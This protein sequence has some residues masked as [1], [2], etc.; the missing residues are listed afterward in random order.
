MDSHGGVE[1]FGAWAE[2]G[3]TFDL[4]HL[5]LDWE[6]KPFF[7]LQQEDHGDVSHHGELIHQIRPT[8]VTMQETI[9]LPDLQYHL[10]SGND[11]RASQL[12]AYL[13][14]HLSEG[15]RSGDFSTIAVDYYK[16]PNYGR[17]L[18]RGPAAQ[19][20]TREAH[21]K[22]LG[23]A[24]EVDASCC[25]P[26]LLLRKLQVL[27]LEDAAGCTMLK[28]F[29]THYQAWR[30]DLAKY[31]GITIDEAKKE[32][33]RTFYGGKAKVDIPWLRK[34]GHEVMIAADLILQHHGHEYMHELYKDR[35]NPDFSRLC[36]LLSF[37][38]A[39]LLDK[40][41]LDPHVK[42][43]VPLFDGGIVST[44]SILEEIYLMKACINASASMIPIDVKQRSAKDTSFLHTLLRKNVTILE[45]G[46]NRAVHSSCLL[47]AIA[48][49][50]DSYDFTSLNKLIEE[51][52]GIGLCAADFNSSSDEYRLQL[53]SSTNLFDD[54][55]FSPVLCHEKGSQNTGH[56]WSL[57]HAEDRVY[58]FDGAAS[59]FTIC[60][61]KK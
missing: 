27:N 29:C 39:E 43:Q 23:Y 13:D 31:M 51:N 28:L 2:W 9:V 32:L 57:Q 18:A 26:R 3:D 58:L 20:L 36:A 61:E 17:L 42:M 7:D 55:E 60:C 22:T 45:D 41:R 44:S 4:R 33:I 56:W 16:A 53:L 50:V 30:E 25:H 24:C 11:R 48:V 52:P 12:Q 35:S 37:D 5:Q 21:A 54:D 1:A 10:A 6:A 47:H 38:E 40:V 15:V 46:S 34:L 49:V 14:R 19:K 8:V 59:P